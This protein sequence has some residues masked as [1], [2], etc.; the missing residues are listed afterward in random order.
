MRKAIFALLIVAL[1]PF[2]GLNVAQAQPIKY[3]QAGMPFL[4]ID[5]GGRAALAGTQIGARGDAM[6]VF[7]NPALL[8]Q[9][10]G[11]QVM[12]SITNWIADIKHYGMAAS[13]NAGNLG[14]FAVSLIWMDYGELR[15][16][17][18]YLGEDPTLRNIGY[19]DQGT[20]QVGEYAVGFA[21]ARWISS[22]FAVGGHLKYAHQD[23]GSVVIYDEIRGENRTQKN[24]LG[25]LAFD[26]GTLFYP[27]FKD[28]RFG[29]SL[30]NFAGQNDYYNQRFELPLTFCFGVAMDVMNFWTPE[31]DRNMK[32]T[33]AFDWVHPRDYSERQHV[34]IEYSL[35]D[36]VFLRAGYKFNY[37]EEGLTAGA[38]FRKDLG[39]VGLNIDYT[40]TSFGIFD[41]VQRFSL[42]V[43]F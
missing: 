22:Q 7:Y 1:L 28:F 24:A 15:R 40:Y 20:F 31:A 38:G 14:T 33:V 29:L 35:A 41:S 13:Y 36:M 25:N 6:S 34:G 8:A 3:A 39:P 9:A 26:F 11:I 17:V 12:S 5:V 32:L 21:Y 10:D 30:R 23:L 2:L 18:P 27:G 43:A 42:G 4:K 16:T 19:I 37:D